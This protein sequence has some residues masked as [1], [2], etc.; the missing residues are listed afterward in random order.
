MEIGNHREAKTTWNL[1]EKTIENCAHYKYLGEII[2]R[3]GSN[4]ENLKERMTKFKGTVIENMTCAKN[5]VM[6]RIQ[7]SIMLKYHEAV[8]LPTLLYGCETWDLKTIEMK[9]LERVELWAL[10]KMF[11]LPPTTPNGAVRYT[12]G[13]MF[14]EVRIHI[15]QIMYFHH[16]LQREN[17]HFAKGAVSTLRHKNIGW[18]KNIEKTLTLWEL[19]TKWDKIAATKKNAWKLEVQK[20]AEKRNQALLLNECQTKVRGETKNKTKTKTILEKIQCK[21]YK[22]IPVS[23]LT[24]LNCIESRALIMGR[25][26]MLDCRAN[27]SNGYGDKMCDLC[28]MIDD[29]KHRMNECEKYKGVNHC[30]DQHKIS[31]DD[32]YHDDMERVKPVID[33]ILTMW[34]LKNGKNKMCGDLEHKIIT[35]IV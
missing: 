22:R 20:A 29:E 30:D 35:G 32:I 23:I 15:K 7:S 25:Y 34:D 1:G 13:T 16:L 26:G 31:F 14:M 10:K 27:F 17:G 18:I 28:G 6:K 33:S 21:D 11:G 12:T 3:N 19:E 9:Q 5:E 4:T 24:H 2:S 8:A